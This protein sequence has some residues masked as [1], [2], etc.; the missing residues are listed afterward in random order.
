ML[1]IIRSGLLS[2]GF[3]SEMARNWIAPLL[4]G[5][6]ILALSVIADFIAKRVALRTLNT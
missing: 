5:L 3:E 1:E 4:V 2:F 6:C